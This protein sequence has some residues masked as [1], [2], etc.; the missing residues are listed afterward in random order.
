MEKYQFEDFREVINAAAG[1]SLASKL[2]ES[3]LL[4]REERFSIYYAPFEYINADARLVIV[5]ITP[6]LQQAVNALNK[7]K[8]GLARGME[9][10]EILRSVKNFASFS[11][12][13]RKNL[14][15]MLDYIGV[16]AKLGIRQSSELFEAKSHYAQFMSV[17]RNPVF[18]D[19]RNYSGSPSMLNT[20]LLR[21]CLEDYFVQDVR[22]L[23]HAWFVPLGPKV[24]EALEW[25]A[26]RGVL[27]EAQILKGIPHPSGANAE[28]IAYFLDKKP[29]EALSSKTNP[30]AIDSQKKRL[31]AQLQA[32]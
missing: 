27:D 4:T 32:F 5:G 28:R 6:G 10:A 8:S 21:D 3:L 14:T 1:F 31:L 25:L 24:T 13:M 19:G 17:L 11:G 18:V 16:P 7:A 2:P 30:A 26:R 20:P 15:E 9:T 22:K 29:R 23:A 12:P